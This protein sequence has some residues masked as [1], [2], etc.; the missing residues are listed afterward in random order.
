MPYCLQKDLNNSLVNC[1]PLS[2]TI[3]VT[4]PNLANHVCMI[5]SVFS[6]VAVFITAISGNL[7]C[8][9]CNNKTCGLERGQRSQCGRV[10]MAILDIPMDVIWCALVR[11]VY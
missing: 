10:A 8:A 11:C 6:V 5:S 2:V 9:S 3:S 1:G 7:L 4:N